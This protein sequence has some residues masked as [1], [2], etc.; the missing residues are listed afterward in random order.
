MSYQ[1]LSHRLFDEAEGEEISDWIRSELLLPGMMFTDEDFRA[2][3]TEKYLVRLWPTHDRTT[4]EQENE[5]E[6]H[7]SEIRD[8]HVSDAFIHDCKRRDEFSSRRPHYEGRGQ[9][10]PEPQAAWMREIKQLFQ[11]TPS[12]RI[13]NAD[14]TSWRLCPTGVTT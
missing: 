13:Y 5:D 2:F 14:E 4:E 3:I 7:W 10:E 8:F 11:M 1:S 12:S 9:F 6:K